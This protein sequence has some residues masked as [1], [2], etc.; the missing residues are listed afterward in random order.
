MHT[1]DGLIKDIEN[2]G[3]DPNGALLI[4]SSMKSIGLVDGGADTVLDALSE[5]MKNGLL[6]FPTHTWRQ[7]GKEIFTFDSRNLPSCGGILPEIFRHRSGVIRSLHP[8][9][10]VAALGHDAAS[11][12]AGEETRTT[13][14]PREGC[15]GKLLDMDAEI[16]FLGCTLRSNTFIHGVEEWEGISDRLD[17]EPQHITIIGPNSEEYQVDMYRHNCLACDDVSQNYIKM[18]PV[19]AKHG[20]IRYGKFGDAKCV[21]GNARRMRELTVKL[22]NREPQLFVTADPVPENW[23]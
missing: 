14:C 5:Y 21:I 23:Y 22:L 6:I 7:I 2:M 20:A 3:L 4:H 17:S 1:K 16:L 15:W 12:T 19:F 8:T 10:S 18:E 9:H 13:P 11:Y